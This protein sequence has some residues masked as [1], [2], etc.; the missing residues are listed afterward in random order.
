MRISTK[1]HGYLDYIVALGLIAAP[2]ILSQAPYGAET[3]VPVGLGIAT[4]IYSLFTDYENGYFR[5]MSMRAHLGL[6]VMNG[7]FLAVSPWLFGFADHIWVPYVV[8]GLI[9]IMVPA[10][11]NPY[12]SYESKKTTEQS[13][14]S[15]SRQQNIA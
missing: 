3:W 5:K 15:G 9:E 1:I 6:D 13:H 14:A 7:V 12:P 11:T 8:V 10:L 4:I 2:L